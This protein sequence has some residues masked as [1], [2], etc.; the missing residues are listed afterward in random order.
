MAFNKLIRGVIMAFNK[1]IRPAVGAQFIGAP[2]IDRP[3]ARRCASQADK[4]ALGAINRPLQR[5]G[6]VC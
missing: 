3:I 1:L 5:A 6:L 4:S 2:P